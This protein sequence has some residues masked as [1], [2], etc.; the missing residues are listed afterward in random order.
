VVGAGGKSWFFLTPD[1]S[2]GDFMEKA[3]SEVVQ[4]SGGNVVGA[5]KFPLSTPDY[6]SYLITA[7]ASKAQV[8]ALSTVGGD[9]LNAMKQASEFGLTDDDKKIVVFN[10]FVNEIHA[11]GL[12]N[13][14]G[15]FLTAVFYWD[16]N[17]N[18]RA[19][20]KR[21]FDRM[22]AM[23]NKSQANTYAAVTHYLRAM[24]ATGTDSAAEVASKMRTFPGEYFGKKAIVRQNGRVV[25]DV[26]L[27]ETKTPA[28]SKYAWDYLKA[29]RTIDGEQA[30]GP[31]TSDCAA[32]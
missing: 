29:V 18:T 27:Y 26:T 11:L 21:F 22:K 9:T 23:P 10:I 12:A 17:E 31:A 32:N 16:E 30:F 13:A 24:Q 15:L 25:Y 20:A 28:E 2:F 14:K 1:Y 3:A 8:F 7:S 6:S 5:V 4:Q 19:W